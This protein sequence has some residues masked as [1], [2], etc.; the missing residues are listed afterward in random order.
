LELYPLRL[1]VYRLSANP[2]TN[3]VNGHPIIALSSK[4]SV[5]TLC[6]HAVDAF[7]QFKSLPYRVWTVDHL[8]LDGSEFPASKLSVGVAESIDES[9]RTLDDMLVE[10]GDNLVVEFKEGADWIVDRDEVLKAKLTASEAPPPLFNSTN[11]FFNRLANTVT[12]PAKA[13][14][15]PTASTT[16]T[17]SKLSSYARPATLAP[18]NSRSRI[19]EP[20]T[21]GLGNM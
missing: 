4:D 17:L 21:M 1:N 15:P 5:K 14:V 9:D 10:N 8:E 2:S 19:Q 7:P 18:S 13:I 16:S 3:D 6:K 11:D 20:G 12:S